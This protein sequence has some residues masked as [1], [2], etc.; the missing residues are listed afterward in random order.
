MKILIR[1]FFILT[2]SSSFLMAS[3]GKIAALRGEVTIERAKQEIVVSM[4]ME[5]EKND[6]IHTKSKA[7]LQIVFNDNTIITMGKN[8]DLA[9]NDY[10]YDERKPKAE[11]KMLSGVFRTVT[12]KIGK[13]APNR[14]KIKTKTATI[15]IRGTTVE[16]STTDD[17]DAVGFSKGHGSVTSDATGETKDV[18]TG[19]MVTVTPNGKMGEVRTLDKKAFLNNDKKEKKKAKKEDAKKE[20][21]SDK[22]T[23]KKE[24]KKEV[25]K[26]EKKEAKKEPKA[27]KKSSKSENKQTTSAEKKSKPEVKKAETKNVVKESNNKASTRTIAKDS[28]SPTSQNSKAGDNTQNSLVVDNASEKETITSGVGAGTDKSVRETEV[29]V[30]LGDEAV[31]PPDGGVQD[32]IAIEP[33]DVALDSTQTD[34]PLD[35]VVIDDTA[36]NDAA[37]VATDGAIAQ[38]TD[39]AVA[40]VINQDVQDNVDETVK[41]EVVAKN[42]AKED[43]PIDEIVPVDEIVPPVDETAPVDE[44]I[45]PVDETAPVDEIVPPV[46]ETAP[47]DEIIPPVD[48]TAPADEIVP[49]VDETVIITD[50]GKTITTVTSGSFFEADTY[51][52]VSF[53]YDL[54][55]ISATINPNNISSYFIQGVNLVVIMPT[56]GEISYG[57]LIIG[58]SITGGLVDGIISDFNIRYDFGSATPISGYMYLVTTTGEAWNV[59]FNNGTATST[60][61]LGQNSFGEIVTGSLNG[62]ALYGSNAQS[63]GG[64][65]SFTSTSSGIDGAFIGNGA[66]S[67][68]EVVPDFVPI[69]T[70]VVNFTYGDYLSLGYWNDGTQDFDTWVN[71]VL[72]DVTEIETLIADNTRFVSTTYYLSPKVFG[73]SSTGTKLTNGAVNLNINFG[74]PTPLSGQISFD[75]TAAWVADIPAGGFVTPNG[76]GTNT[77]SDAQS[78]AVN[79][80]GGFLNGSFFGT[81]A[82][83]VGGE[84]GFTGM[85]AGV[86]ESVKGV[87]A[88][89]KGGGG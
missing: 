62:I 36:T 59:G 60:T 47:V 68:E 56:Q 80:I 38:A 11:F 19:Q 63:I 2:L 12:G 58:D 37:S 42:D 26:Q 67:F 57:G 50:S 71:G 6:L 39:E 53:G 32:D 1:L 89:G 27:E 76:F 77:F 72:T 85:N 17:G 86:E 8:A 18:G 24:P 64:K 7:K 13:I 45:P 48:E 34:I 3:I 61:V 46:D 65:F 23:D 15:G 33:V 28:G 83:A 55:D 73:F 22:K 78:S 40:G 75:T 10:L 29:N 41:K 84:F 4:G 81:D 21:K 79:G 70:Q 25:K 74:S 31:A 49:P 43:V 51:S 44:I 54:F 69:D 88:V 52:D 82:A 5:I 66:S 9:V 30:D 20:K 87:F 14:F 35:D 16:I